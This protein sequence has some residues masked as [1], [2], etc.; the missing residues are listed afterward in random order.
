MIDQIERIYRRL[1]RV[2]GYGEITLVDDS[3]PVQL[4]QVRLDQ[5]TVQDGVPR[6]TEYGFQSNPPPGADAALAFL[7]GSASDGV[8][9][10]T[11]H[12]TWRLRGLA[13]GEVAISDDKG[14]KVYLSAAG[15]RI[16][17]GSMPMQINA[18]VGLTINANVTINGTVTA[19]GH[20]IDETHRHGGVQTGSGNTGVVT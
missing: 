1:L 19:N 11:G 14:Q 6:L 17:G 15:I 9:I 3:G 5:I 18:S 8:S 7:M 4:V 2:I 20:R 16:E 13:T 12:Q 10:A